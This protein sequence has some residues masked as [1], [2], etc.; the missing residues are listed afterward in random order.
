MLSE[1]K[2]PLFIVIDGSSMLATSYYALLPMDIK[3]TKDEKDRLPLYGKLMH[4]ADGTYTNAVYGMAGNLVQ[5]LEE[6]KP[7]YLAVVFDQGR[8]TFRRELYQDYKA[9]RGETPQPLKQ[10]FKLIQELLADAGIKVLSDRRYE[11]DDL[12]GAITNK[13]SRDARIRLLTKDRDY[14][15]L[16]ND[17]NNV[18]C[19]IFADKEKADDFRTRYG[20]C[21]MD[22]DMIVPHCLGNIMEFTEDSVYGEKGVYPPY[23]PDLKA[24]E[25]DAS[26]NIP[27]VHGVSSAAAPLIMEYGGLEDIY[28]MIEECQDNK[29]EKE[30]LKFWKE[31][32]GIKRSPLKPLRE[33]KENAILSKQ[34]ARIKTDIP[35]EGSIYDFSTCFISVGTFN[36]WMRKLDIKTIR[37]SEFA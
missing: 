3:V 16:V 5:L 28:D 13:F 29:E 30:I 10:Q 9:Q 36:Q 17:E 14:L 24:I 23:I 7:E 21:Y 18:R 8:D 20:A 32:L 37:L 34:L 25:G 22:S 31:N 33:Q 2:R 15:Q 26:D 1:K 19:W 12:A 35:L 27:G 6:L 11:A 4:A